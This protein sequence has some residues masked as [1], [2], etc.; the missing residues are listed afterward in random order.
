M[1][2][3]LSESHPEQGTEDGAQF[4]SVSRKVV[5]EPT[6]R[7]IH[8]IE[9]TDLLEAATRAGLLL[10]SPC[11]GK[12][13]CGKCRVRISHGKCPPSDVCR[14]F[15]SA[16]ELADGWRLAC[17]CAVLEDMTVEIPESSLFETRSRILT[18]DHGRAVEG[19]PSVAVRPFVLPPPTLEDPLSDAERMDNALGAEAIPLELIRILPGRLRDQD[20][21]GKALVRGSHLVDIWD[22]TDP[23]PCLAVAFDV[24]T[25]TIVGV[26]LDLE[27]GTEPAIVADLNPQ[28]PLGDDVISRI[29]LVREDA[30]GV[31]DMQRA[32][33][34]KLNEI[35]AQL[36]GQAGVETARIADVSIAGNTTMQHLL[37]GITPA[38]LG[39]IPFAPAYRLPI[40]LPARELGLKVHPRGRAFVFPNIGGFV[41]GDTVAGI[42]AHD[43]MHADKPVMLVDIGTNGEIAVARNGVVTATSC[44]A[45]PAFEGARISAGMRAAAGAIEKVALDNEDFVC[46]V[47]GGGEAVGVCGTALIDAAAELLR[48][49]ILD[50]T[51][52]LLGPD[53]APKQ[54][55]EPVR[56]R[57]HQLNGEIHLLLVDPDRSANGKGI[58]LTQADIRELQL[59]SGAIRAGVTIMLR[60]ANIAPRDLEAVLLA[61]GFG[62]Y[63]RRE[64]ACRMGLLPEIPVERIRFVG[65]S[66]LAGAKAVLTACELRETAAEITRRTARL[67]LSLDTDFQ[68]EFGMAMMFPGEDGTMGFG[69]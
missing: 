63:I 46:N 32:V 68:M 5:F 8:T 31:A 6:G 2:G 58:Y 11:G 1:F 53:E 7:T 26:L 35:L 54:V 25:T 20:F 42:L 36:A 13:V 22:E 14:D 17:R 23:A 66:S 27:S 51:G 64:N 44:A 49:G 37:C 47:I 65:N 41:G 62:N 40:D 29:A 39:E 33:I 55:P 12:G 15:L 19:T 57:L 60:K 69:L 18:D 9:G 38:A 52:R 67:D 16:E 28:I 34:D 30:N 45:G 50:A 59:A 48:L 21:R 24:G 43:L 10:K 4:M 61:G 56:Q 3:D